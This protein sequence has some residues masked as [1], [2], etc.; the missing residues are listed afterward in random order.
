LTEVVGH[1]HQKIEV[2]SMQPLGSPSI[3]VTATS[4]WA[5]GPKVSH[6]RPTVADGPKYLADVKYTSADISQ[7]MF[8]NNLP[9]YSPEMLSPKIP[10][11]DTTVRH[12]PVKIDLPPAR[13]PSST[14][15]LVNKARAIKAYQN[16]S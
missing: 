9:A 10:Y 2:F 3:G 4:V 11:I 15:V 12:E 13:T 14:A 16:V 1:L 5:Y 8:M 7:M 6:F